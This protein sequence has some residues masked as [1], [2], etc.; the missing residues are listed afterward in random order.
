M[1]GFTLRTHCGSREGRHNASSSQS[2]K[3]GDFFWFRQSVEKVTTLLGKVVRKA[4]TSQK[5]WG[6]LEISC[7]L[8]HRVRPR[9]REHIRTGTFGRLASERRENYLKGFQ[10]LCKSRLGQAPG[11]VLLG[12]KVSVYSSVSQGC[13]LHACTQRLSRRF[14]PPLPMMN[15]KTGVPDILQGGEW[16]MRCDDQQLSGVQG[17]LAHEK[18]PALLGPPRT[19]G[20]CLR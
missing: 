16:G 4:G 13:R 10:N 20:I 15:H 9:R 11:T 1:S 5:E 12:P 7:C 18:T 19:I 17:Y 2:V 8:L 14:H 3:G 6:F